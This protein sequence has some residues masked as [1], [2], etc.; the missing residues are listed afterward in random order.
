MTD[1]YI[2]GITHEPVLQKFTKFFQISETLTTT[3]VTGSLI[4]A[5]VCAIIYF[6][7]KS[8]IGGGKDNSSGTTN[9]NDSTSS[10]VASASSLEDSNSIVSISESDELLG[11]SK[12]AGS[13]SFGEIINYFVT[14]N[15]GGLDKDNWI[16]FTN[17]VSDCMNN[18]SNG[19]GDFCKGI[20]FY[21][22][23]SISLFLEDNKR[24]E[25]FSIIDPLGFLK[26][27]DK[28]FG[29]TKSSEIIKG[30][31]DKVSDNT[32]VFKIQD[33]LRAFDI[34]EEGHIRN[35]GEVEVILNMEGAVEYFSLF[36][37][38][39]ICR[40]VDY[41]EIK[42]LFSAALG[43]TLYEIILQSGLPKRFYEKGLS[44][45]KDL[46]FL[47]KGFCIYDYFVLF[48]KSFLSII[49]ESSKHSHYSPKN[50]AL[51]T[52]ERVIFNKKN[53]KHFC[54]YRLSDE[55]IKNYSEKHLHYASMVYW[56]DHN[57]SIVN[58]L[59][60][61]RPLYFTKRSFGMEKNCWNNFVSPNQSGSIAFKESLY[62]EVLDPGESAELNKSKFFP[63]FWSEVIQG[64]DLKIKEFG[65]KSFSSTLK[66]QEFFSPMLE[67]LYSFVKAQKKNYR[68]LCINE[69]F[70]IFIYDIIRKI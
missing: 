70:K 16:D 32:S 31:V 46:N 22:Q 63:D 36:H 44:T 55:E 20:L 15:K 35:V 47:L 7:K 2:K 3:A 37:A 8:S 34:L 30:L 9:N 10:D 67:C 41:I 62:L 12:Q 59:N 53:I 50:N 11:I 14:T 28:E 40:D 4:V 33:H 39:F 5:G 54:K 1:V 19:A 21:S 6:Y 66:K 45:A 13:N 43:L 48:K 23:D 38:C 42:A 60:L 52:I 18:A 24:Y 64:K 29:L 57:H 56:L 69:H 65:G 25:K 51:L 58:A 68:S 26:S 61:S 27:W 17:I 49:F